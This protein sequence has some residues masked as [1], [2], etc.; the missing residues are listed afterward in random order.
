MVVLSPLIFLV[1][2]EGI[3]RLAGAGFPPEFF[4]PIQGRN[5]LTTNDRFGWRYFPRQLA[6]APVPAVIVT[7]KPAGLYRV[8]VLG[9]SAAMGFPEPSFGMARM[10]SAL[11]EARMP[12]RRVE[13]INA[14]MTAINSHAMAVIAREC[15]RLQP[16]AVVIMAGNNEVVGPRGPGTVFP[17][18]EEWQQSARLGQVLTRWISPAHRQSEWRGMEMFERHVVAPNDHRLETVYGDFEENLAESVRVSR[19]ASAAVVVLTIPVNLTEPP[20]A[21]PDGKA[22]QAFRSGRLE[23]ACDLDG[24][25]FRADSRIRAITAGYGVDPKISPQDFYEHVHLRPE[26]NYRAAIAAARALH[27][28]F[29]QWPP[30]DRVFERVAL[31]GWDRWRMES[32][33]V[34]LMERPPFTGRLD[35]QARLARRRGATEAM[36]RDRGAAREAY[37]AALEAHPED[38]ALRARFAEFLREAGYPEESTT[39]YRKVVEVLPGNKALTASLG[40]ALSDAGQ[41]TEAVEA[42]ESA[43]RLDPEFDLA[44]FGKAIALERSGAVDRAEASYRAALAINPESREA[45]GNLALL[46]H[47]RG[48]RMARGGRVPEAIEMFG[49]ALAAKPDFAEAHYDLGS[50]LSRQGESARAIPHLEQAV[51]LKPESADAHNNLGTALARQGDFASASVEFEEALRHRPDFEAARQNLERA[52]RAAKGKLRPR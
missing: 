12:G 47:A 48:L 24:L 23:Q 5:R 13:V 39:Q 28:D 44:L 19:Q 1:S 37:R 46:L 52:R 38:F 17:R 8:F 2:V 18:I 49:K 36:P 11:L 42:F 32:V 10:L 26:G 30:A 4:V 20:F 25:R 51:R 33:I 31:T 3:L 34:A 50:L 6:R 7:P 15:S 27:P 41:H 14:A 43:L 35:A 16:D 9:E 21:S 45:S 40:S 29:G 22:N